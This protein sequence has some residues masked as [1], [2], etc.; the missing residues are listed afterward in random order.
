MVF[1]V[2]GLLCAR[3]CIVYSVSTVCAVYATVAVLVCVMCIVWLVCD[4]GCGLCVVV[5]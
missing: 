2:C 3:L 4:A 1:S 5:V